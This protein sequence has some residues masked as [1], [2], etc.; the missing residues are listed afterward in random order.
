MN[1]DKYLYYIIYFLITVPLVRTV[2]KALW[3][4]FGPIKTFAICLI[5][6]YGV[7]YLIYHV[8][9]YIIEKVKKWCTT[10]MF[11]ISIKRSLI[12]DLENGIYLEEWEIKYL[13]KY[14]ITYLGAFCK[15]D[16]RH[17][18]DPPEPLTTFE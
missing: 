14:T 5:L 15:V 17:T 12:S 9:K 1:T 16:V 10:E 6:A 7:Y 13:L 4:T 2:S 8:L 11:T 18:S 3:E